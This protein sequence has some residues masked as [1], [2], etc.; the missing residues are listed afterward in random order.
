MTAEQARQFSRIYGKERITNELVRIRKQ[1]ENG[2][3]E[4]RL[5]VN[6][7]PEISVEN[8]QTLRNLG[9]KILIDG[10]GYWVSWDGGDRDNG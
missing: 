1:I 10:L 2:A 6:V 5:R 3:R 7:G 9:Y 8:K 4:G